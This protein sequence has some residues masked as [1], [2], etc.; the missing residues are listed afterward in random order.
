MLFVI[1]Y[2]IVHKKVFVYKIKYD[3]TKKIFSNVTVSGTLNVMPK[4][5]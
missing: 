2:S 5:N 3:S 4:T 1:K